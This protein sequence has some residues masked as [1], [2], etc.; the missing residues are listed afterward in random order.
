MVVKFIQAL[1]KWPRIVKKLMS[2]VKKLIPM[3]K[4]SMHISNNLIEILILFCEE[5]C[6]TAYILTSIAMIGYLSEDNLN[7]AYF[8][9][10]EKEWNKSASIKQWG[11][12]VAKENDYWKDKRINYYLENYFK[13]KGTRKY[14]SKIWYADNKSVY[15]SACRRK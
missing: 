8:R 3:M 10:L 6:L 13:E 1:K 14:C 9:T 12:T 5:M 2:T 7:A 15:E 4:K 11:H